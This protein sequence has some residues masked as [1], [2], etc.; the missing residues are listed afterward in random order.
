MDL[1]KK[2]KLI[3][4]GIVGTGT[5]S[6]GNYGTPSRQISKPESGNRIQNLLDRNQ[7]RATE[8]ISS[9][10]SETTNNISVNVTIDASGKE[11]VEASSP[12]SSY[13]KE[14]D[15]AMKIKSKVLEVIREEKRLGGE[16]G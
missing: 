3:E 5:Q 2:H 11:S 6:T 16:L 9:S 12:E 14:Q 7:E 8:N 13:E 15:L 4:G 1:E 10:N